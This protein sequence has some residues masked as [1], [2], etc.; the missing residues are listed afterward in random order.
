MSNWDES[1]QI[2]QYV[3]IAITTF[4]A[5]VAVI[6]R[7]YAQRAYRKGWGLDDAFIVIALLIVYAEFVSSI[8]ALNAG[9]GLHQ[10]RVLHEDQNPP[11]GLQYIYTNYWIVSILWAP[12]VTF[13]KLSILV[14]YRRILFVQQRW[15]NLALWLNAA[16]AVALGIAS[17]FLYVFQCAPVDYYW[18]RYVDYYGDAAPNGKCLPNTHI[19]LGLP[20]IMSTVSDVAI[21]ALPV[22]I[23]WN[24]MVPK[25]RKVAVSA[26]FFLGAFTVG[27][28]IA[29]IVM[30]FRVS[31]TDDVTWVNIDTVT[32]TVVEAAVGIVCA[33]LPPSA[34]LYTH[35]I[36]KLGFNSDSEKTL[37]NTDL[38]VDSK[39]QKRG[40]SSFL[41]V[42]SQNTPNGG[43][44]S[45]QDL[46]AAE[47]GAQV[48]SPNPSDNR[49][50][51]ISQFEQPENGILVRNKIE[52]STDDYGRP[53]HEHSGDSSSETLKEEEAGL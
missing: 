2:Q 12:G 41:R 5:T 28:G 1:R 22:P 51:F 11:Q 25:S 49:M 6:I 21:L 37:H 48:W 30:S 26:V 44:D 42:P 24:L 46:V 3:A 50:S 4:A 36:K 7:L 33:C 10:V 20:Q 40:T 17:F 38:I 23:I 15:F 45:F 34:P 35:F 18:T 43:R 39:S 14:L 9:A 47:N 8:L 27:C 19:Y 52:L 16:Y 13:V 29:R 53:D 32:F 31:N